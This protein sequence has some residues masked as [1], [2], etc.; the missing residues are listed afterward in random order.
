MKQSHE[1]ILTTHTGSLPRPQSLLDMVLA[2]ERGEL[3][4]SD[5]FK[6]LL[7]TSTRDVV[8][9]QI[10]AGIDIVS[11]GEL[12]K[13][14]Y[15]TYVKDRLTGFH[16]VGR[17]PS[18][19]DLAEYPAYM[20]KELGR[21]GLLTLKMPACDGG[22][23]YVGQASLQRDIANFKHALEGAHCEEAFMTAAS[24]GVISL[25][26]QNRFYP[27]HEAYLSALADAMRSEY[28]AIH[29]AGFMLQIDCPDLAM[30][31]HIQFADQ[32]LDEFRKQAELHVEAL[33]RAVANIPADRMRIHVCWANYEGPHHR[34]VALRDI[35]EVV[36]RARPAGLSFVAANPRHEHEWKVWRDVALPHG[37]VLIPGVI[38]STTNFIEHPELV[39]ERI[40]RFADIVGP[41]QVIAGTDCGFATFAAMAT[42]D[43]NIA[44]AKLA[45]LSEGAKLATARLYRRSHRVL[46]GVA[47]QTRRAAASL[48]GLRRS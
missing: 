37:K 5:A 6:A 20:E 16:G 11:D 15:S 3:P 38:D 17:A 43:P 36:L 1:R 29:R 4:Q 7:E 39:A 47:S 8:R 24:P 40:E 28:E 21:D 13:P 9:Q 23:E 35:V 2:Q 26:L 32:S 44:W 19:A 22:V 45:A 41:E 30:G 27:S 48:R 34:D 31:R 25:F 10:E 14:G 46:V 42:I 33:N 18:V 12:S